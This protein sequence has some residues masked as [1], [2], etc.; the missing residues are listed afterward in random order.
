MFCLG[1]CNIDFFVS[2]YCLR[3][4]SEITKIQESEK[5]I[6]NSAKAKVQNYESE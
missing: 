6:L 4:M 5:T 2:C 3:I 1:N